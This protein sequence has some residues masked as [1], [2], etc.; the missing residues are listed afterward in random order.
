MLQFVFSVIFI[1]HSKIRLYEN[2]YWIEVTESRLN[3]IT[4]QR[5]WNSSLFDVVTNI[6]G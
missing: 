3:D 1:V 5:H 6:D 2:K 4:L